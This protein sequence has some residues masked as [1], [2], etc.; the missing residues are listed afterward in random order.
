MVFGPDSGNL[1]QLPWAIF[2]HTH[3]T[4]KVTR[5]RFE[6]FLVDNKSENFNT[7]TS[8][9]TH[10]FLRFV[11]AMPSI[12]HFVLYYSWGPLMDSELLRCITR[13]P[14]LEYFSFDPNTRM[15]WLTICLQ[16]M[17]VATN[18]LFPSLRFLTLT[19]DAKALQFLLPRLPHLQGVSFEIRKSQPGS[20]ASSSTLGLLSL[21]PLL[22]AVTF[23]DEVPITSKSLSD[24]ASGCPLIRCLKIE[25]P[26]CKGSLNGEVFDTITSKWR[27]LIELD[28]GFESDLS[29][30]VFESLARHCCHLR[31]LYLMTD[32]NF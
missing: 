27:H 5:A 18:G 20:T 28:L 25:G 21:C 3:S 6:I 23:Y 7:D 15:Q 32:V 8:I 13:R 17:G 10:H 2:L 31:N 22:E 26:G 11:Q 14:N 9:T 1:R 4:R 16:E 24:L 30:S 12:T 19:T 29:V